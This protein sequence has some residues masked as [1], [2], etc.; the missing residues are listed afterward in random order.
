M[1]R[2]QVEPTADQLGGLLQV[3]KSGSA[4]YADFSLWGPQGRRA[5]KKLIHSAALFDPN[6]GTWV[7]NSLPG[8]PNSQS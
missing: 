7:Q 1:P 5:L 8:P 4:P 6:T 3:L 2:E